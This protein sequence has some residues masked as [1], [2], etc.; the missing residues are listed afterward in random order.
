MNNLKITKDTVV[1]Y[2]GECPDGF[3]AAWVAW[4]KFGDHADYIPG[5]HGEAPPEELTNK[6]IYF[7]DFVYPTDLMA[8]IVKNSK[9]V[10]VIDHHKSVEESVKM[11]HEYVYEMDHSAA[12]LSWMYFYPDTAI[13]WL[14][15][16]VEDM[17]LWNLEL[18]DILPVA[19]FYNTVNKDFDTWSK[20]AKDFD[21]ESTRSRYIE[22]GKIML[23][24]EAKLINEI[25]N[26]NKE[27]VQFEGHEVYSVNSP[28]AFASQIGNALCA[29]KPPVAIVWQWSNG[30]IEVSL[31]SDGSVDV[32]EIAKKF[33]GGGHKTAAGFKFGGKPDFP[34]KPLKQNNDK[35]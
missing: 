17:D 34:W 18:P 29:E 9:R 30:G 24:Y 2:H 3:S 6:E 20:L 15:R 14:L 7:L 33:G 35:K 16:Y 31:R 26:S 12:V 8:K 5:H 22:E 11:A 4:K 28:H 25:I 13:P 27:T 23:K 19:L 1:I 32:S 21:D 10:V